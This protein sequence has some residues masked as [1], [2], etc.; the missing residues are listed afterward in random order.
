VQLLDPVEVPLRIELLLYAWVEIHRRNSDPREGQS[1][2][3]EQCGTGCH[4]SLNDHPGRPF[5][6]GDVEY[7]PEGQG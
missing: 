2:H 6:L 1:E 5:R 3:D 7:P 4:R